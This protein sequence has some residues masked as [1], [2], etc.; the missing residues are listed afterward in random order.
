MSRHLRNF[1]RYL[2]R[3]G[4]KNIHEW[5]N[6]SGIKT[7]E[8]L[9]EYCSARQLCV[10]L[11]AYDNFFSNTSP[12]NKPTTRSNKTQKVNSATEESWHVPAAERPIKKP[13]KASKKTAS[14]KA[15]TSKNKKG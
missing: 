5:L 15:S 10:E 11:S 1:E 7:P 12:S 9:S 2:T 6:K 4:V 3:R 13:K 14:H 8:Q